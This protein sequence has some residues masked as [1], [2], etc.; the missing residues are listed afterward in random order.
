MQNFALRPSPFALRPCLRYTTQNRVVFY[1]LILL[2]S[3]LSM[4][5]I[6]AQTASCFP[7][8]FE[9]CKVEPTSPWVLT[10]TPSTPGAYH[11]YY[12]VYLKSTSGGGAAAEY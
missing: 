9:I 3:A 11:T 10:S 6:Q 1:W 2:V 12:Q 7:Y 8:Y 5:R 4:S